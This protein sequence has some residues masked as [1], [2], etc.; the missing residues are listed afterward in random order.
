MT[1]RLI[2]L[3]STVKGLE[4]EGKN[5]RHFQA[6]IWEKIREEGREERKEKTKKPQG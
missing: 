1:E 2:N 4:T 6:V 5:T 3:L